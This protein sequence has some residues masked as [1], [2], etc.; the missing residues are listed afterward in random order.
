MFVHIAEWELPIRLIAYPE[1][2]LQGW[3]W[4]DNLDEDHARYTRTIAVEVPGEETELL[5]E[6]AKRHNAYIL[7]QVKSVDPK[8]IG[9]RHFNTA[10]LIDPQGKVILKHY[11]LQI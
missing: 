10:F 3:A 6:I 7:G 1:G 2:V 5:G 11:K 8:I 9:D 4:H